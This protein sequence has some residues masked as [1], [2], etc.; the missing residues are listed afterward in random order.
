MGLLGLLVYLQQ[1]RKE[2]LRVYSGEGRVGVGDVTSLA[3]FRR[4]PHTASRMQIL[5]FA[6]CCCNT[7]PASVVWLLIQPV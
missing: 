2:Q 3:P 5:Y 7:I 1:Q 6:L 4:N